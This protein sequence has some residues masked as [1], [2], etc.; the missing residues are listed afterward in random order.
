[1]LIACVC[2]DGSSLLPTLIYEGKAALQSSWVEDVKA[3]IHEVF[4]ANLT[5]G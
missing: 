4:I 3:G 5:S 1:M 2:S